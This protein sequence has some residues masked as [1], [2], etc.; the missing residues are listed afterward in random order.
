MTS[1]CVYFVKYTWMATHW[2]VQHRYIDGML[3][4]SLCQR[5]YLSEQRKKEVMKRAKEK[6]AK[7]KNCWVSELKWPQDHTND[8]L[9]ICDDLEKIYFEAD[10]VALLSSPFFFCLFDLLLF[11]SFYN[12][13]LSQIISYSLSELMK[14]MLTAVLKPTL[15]NRHN[16]Q[17]RCEPIKCAL[18][19]D[20]TSISISSSRFK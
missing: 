15:S 6:K 18:I 9:Y 17:V 10:R 1:K 4:F 16:R 14:N 5:N 19:V 13:L 20:Y 3:L 2:R 12:F 7:A 8:D 11:E